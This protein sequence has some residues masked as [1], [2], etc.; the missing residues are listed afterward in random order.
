[1]KTLTYLLL[2]V[3]N[4]YAANLM[5]QETKWV[6]DKA[7]T[8]IKFSATHMAISD[9][10]GKFSDYNVEVFAD[11]QDFDG[12]N[13]KVTIDAKSI[14]TDNSKRDEHL[15]SDEFLGVSQYPE[16]K[17]TGKLKENSID[18]EYTLDGVLTIRDVSKTAQLNVVHKGTVE[19]MGA[20]RAGFKITGTIDRFDYNVDWNK[21]FTSGL[22]VGKKVDIVCDIELNKAKE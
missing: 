13:V 22:V 20:V 5:A 2:V 14:D 17:F 15:R 10:D 1:M 16:I 3:F 21:T 8:K 19:A 4:L 7:H 11:G 12:A 6:A 9:V 18:G